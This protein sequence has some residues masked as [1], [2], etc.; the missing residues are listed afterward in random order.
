MS[1]AEAAK[2]LAKINT[3]KANIYR[4]IDRIQVFVL[5][6]YSGENQC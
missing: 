6:T 2:A 1:V 4:E 5:S 3:E